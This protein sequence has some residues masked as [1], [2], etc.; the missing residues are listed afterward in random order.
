MRMEGRTTCPVG[1]CAAPVL[2]PSNL[3]HE[4]W[5]AG[6]V[7][8]V[9]KSTMIITAWY[10]EHGDEAGMIVLNDF[11]LGDLFGADRDSRRGFD[12]KGLS[13]SAI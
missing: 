5:L 8:C 13:T 4:H 2:G 6:G 9:G 12:G 10:A 11:A 3:C 7:M 1:G